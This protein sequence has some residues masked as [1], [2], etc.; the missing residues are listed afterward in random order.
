MTSRSVDG[1]AEIVRQLLGRALAPVGEEVRVPDALG[2]VLAAD[3]RAPID[4]P[5][6]R[7]SQMDGYAVDSASLREV[8]V[9]LPVT[10]IVA[11]G[12]AGPDRLEAGTAIKIMTGAPVPA[13]ADCVVPVEDT[14]AG[15]DRVHIRVARR[16][17]EFVRDRGSDVTS[18]TLLLAAGAELTARHLAM[19]AAVGLAEVPVLRRPRFA[20][21]ATGAELMPAGTALAPGQIFESNSVALAASVRANG[22]DAVLVDHSTD[23]P[24]RFRELLH[25]AVDVADVVI[26]S[27]GVSMGDFE[28]VREVLTPL[29]GW[30][31]HVAM[32]PG[33]PQ[34]LTTVQGVPVLS[35]PGNPVSTLISFE[36]FARAELRRCAGLAP[37]PADYAPLTVPV[38]SPSG[39]RQFLRGRRVADGVTLESGPGSHLVAAFARADVLL[40][41]P[42]DVTT[43]QAGDDVRVW[44]L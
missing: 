30:F 9:S 39:K 43:M 22:G 35:F 18:G 38:E 41:I 29:G 4:L 3:V 1:H 23:V 2:R 33:G 42:E 13:G 5:V 40:D 10:A 20:V 24:D 27:G 17:G 26:T 36:V 7:N 19:L 15:N 37:L 34:G 12:D 8:P 32:Q 44:E 6:F 16:P 14:D 11:A 28:V 21:I 31:G 25:R